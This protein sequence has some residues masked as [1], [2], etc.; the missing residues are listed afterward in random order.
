METMICPF[1]LTGGHT[2]HKNSL[3]NNG[4]RVPV[5]IGLRSFKRRIARIRPRIERIRKWKLL[6]LIIYA[7]NWHRNQPG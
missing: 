4:G 7:Q 6:E 1:I 3:Y 2:R 5:I